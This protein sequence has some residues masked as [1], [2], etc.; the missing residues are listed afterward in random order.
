MTTS[1]SAVPTAIIALAAACV[2]L[3]GCK[4]DTQGLATLEIAEAAE[5]LAGGSNVVF[6]DANTDDTRQKY[7]VIQGAHLLSS[8]D[9]YDPASEVSLNKTLPVVFYCHS[10]RC[11]AAAGAARR[12]VA[13]GYTDVF[14]LPGGI[15]GWV[16]AGHPVAPVEAS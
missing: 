13:A 1:R 14:V 6:C 2:L 11:S 12:A 7:G 9:D 5:L 15:T 3:S 4:A 8:Y 10:E 16:D